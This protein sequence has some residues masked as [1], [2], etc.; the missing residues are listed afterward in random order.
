MGT[1]RGLLVDPPATAAAALV[2]LASAHDRWGAHLAL[3]G[4]EMLAEPIGPVAGPWADASKAAYV[5]HMLD[6]FV[7]HGA[8]ISLLRDLWHWQQQ[9][10]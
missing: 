7:H 8:E 2:L 1:G 10:P 6:E 9:A 5:L 3:A 4:D